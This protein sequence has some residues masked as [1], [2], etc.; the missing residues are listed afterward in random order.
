MFLSDFLEKLVPQPIKDLFNFDPAPEWVPHPKDFQ[1]EEQKYDSETAESRNINTSADVESDGEE[2]WDDDEFEE[3]INNHQ[4]KGNLHWLGRDVIRS[5]TQ[6]TDMFSNISGGLDTDRNFFS[7]LLGGFKD[8]I[9]AIV[10]G[11]RV[12]IYSLTLT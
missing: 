6:L 9:K 10:P 12:Y 11:R 7:G 3:H 8:K 5:L 1:N 2:G 4:E